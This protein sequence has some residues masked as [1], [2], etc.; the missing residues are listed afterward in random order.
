[1]EKSRRVVRGCSQVR[2]PREVA[3]AYL[4]TFTTN[5]EYTP[6]Q[7]CSSTGV[8]ALLRAVSERGLSS[9]ELEG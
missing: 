7:A 3:E 2:I 9:P 8:D 5:E 4:Q 6:P 1:M